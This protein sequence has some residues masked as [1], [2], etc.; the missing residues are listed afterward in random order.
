[1]TG[2]TITGYGTIAVDT[3]TYKLP[4][5]TE[6]EVATG[7]TDVQVNGNSVVSNKVANITISKSDTKC[8]SLTLS[9]GAA[10][11]P[12]GDTVEVIENKNITASGTG[13]SLSGTLT[14]VTVPTK[15]YTDKTFATLS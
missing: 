13:T 11:T 12:S 2:G 1:L 5:H 7:V 9:Q 8:T 3:S 6:W 14:A 10:T 15:E 4:T